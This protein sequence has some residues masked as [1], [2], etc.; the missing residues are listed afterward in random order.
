MIFPTAALSMI[1]LRVLTLP[2]L[3]RR[4]M[5]QKETG[6]LQNLPQIEIESK[7]CT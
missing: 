4:G 2:M 6:S 5:M 1:V 3:L 7:L